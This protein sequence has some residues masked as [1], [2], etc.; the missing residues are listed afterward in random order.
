MEAL[1]T[2]LVEFVSKYPVLSSVMLVMSLLRAVNK[3]LF[4][5]FRAYVAA[6]PNPADDMVL[7]KVEQSGVY[8]AFVYALD[9]FASVKLVK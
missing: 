7:D 2:L 9:W 5:L 3:P 4:S 8:K 1:Q 6:T